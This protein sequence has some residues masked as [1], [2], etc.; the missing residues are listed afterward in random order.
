MLSPAYQFV[1]PPASGITKGDSFYY[2]SSV[3]GELKNFSLAVGPAST[4]PLVIAGFFSGSVAEK[5][6]RKWIIGVSI[7]M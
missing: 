3:I 7:I 2:I 4:V 5:V 1:P 6:N